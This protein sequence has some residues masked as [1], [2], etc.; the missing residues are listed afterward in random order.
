[1]PLEVSGREEAPERKKRE[2]P[3]SSVLES[4]LEISKVITTPNTI[5]P[6]SI[7]AASIDWK[8]PAT[9]IKTWL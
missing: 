8:G 7:S 4:N 1:M 3:F 2:A 6:V 5:T 9:P